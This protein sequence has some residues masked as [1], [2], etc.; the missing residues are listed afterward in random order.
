MTDRHRHINKWLRENHQDITHYYDVWHVA[1]G[2]LLI[3]IFRL[4][5]YA[6]IIIGFRK[7]LEAASKQKDCD[8]IAQWQRSIINHLYGDGET[9]KT[10]WLSLEN[11]VHNIHTGHGESFPE[12]AHGRLG[13][14]KK[15]WFKR[16]KQMNK[17]YK[18]KATFLTVLYTC[19]MHLPCVDTKSSERLT[20]LLTNKLLCKDFVSAA[21]HIIP[22]SFP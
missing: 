20:A 19:I 4:A 12:C 3:Y 16:R 17:C 18:Y 11:H 14:H 13:S 1:K 7:K 6:C 9:I 22:G 5:F 21:P 10:K 8:N 2:V 15:K